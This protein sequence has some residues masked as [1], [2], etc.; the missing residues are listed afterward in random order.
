[1]PTTEEVRTKE[2]QERESTI[3]LCDSSWIGRTGIY[4][5]LILLGKV[6][7]LI[8]NKYHKSS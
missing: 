3:V 1:M 6:K 5:W 8:T 4:I 7:Q 2:E